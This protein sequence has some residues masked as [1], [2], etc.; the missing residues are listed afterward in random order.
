MSS[1]NRF[2][3][4]VA[5]LSGSASSLKGARMGFGGSTAWKML[6]EGGKVVLTDIQDDLGNAAAK[7]MRGEGY[8]AIYSHLNVVDEANWSDV[9]GQTVERFGRIDILVNL[10]GAQDRGT[11][12][13]VDVEEWRRVMEI[14]TTGILLG[15]RA[16]IPA[17][18]EVGGGAIV[19]LSSMAG[20]FAGE[21]GSAYAM[22]RAGMLHFTRASAIQLAKFGIR[23]NSVLPG[24]GP[25]TVHEAH[26]RGGFGAGMAVEERVPLGRWGEPEEVA[27]AICFLASDEASYI[28][29]SEL[30]IDGGVTAGFKGNTM[31]ER[32]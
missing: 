27:D 21:Y 5:L 15:T 11:L 32:D 26:I 31:P 30:L 4:K 14:S 18:K 16:V 25:H 2:E 29:G 1:R 8:D 19:N 6:E 28:T 20:K 22:S 23:A 3:G 9:V 7:Q 13:E 12:Y 10:A 24:L 17:M